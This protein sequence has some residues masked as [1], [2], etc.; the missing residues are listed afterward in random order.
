MAWSHCFC[1]HTHTQYLCPFICWWALMS[2][3]HL[4]YCKQCCCEHCT[5]CVFLNFGFLQV[6]AQEWNVASIK[7]QKVEQ[8]YL[9]HKFIFARNVTFFSV[10][11]NV[12]LMSSHQTGKKVNPVILR[13]SS[14]PHLLSTICTLDNYKCHL[15][16]S[17][18]SLAILRSLS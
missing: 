11:L 14:P 18:R 16:G 9:F 8:V 17:C 2:L 7:W 6:Y 3:S 12:T 5:A 15:I 1:V 13:V 10:I 4:G